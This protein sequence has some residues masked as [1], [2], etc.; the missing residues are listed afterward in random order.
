M[1]RIVVLENPIAHMNNQLTKQYFTQMLTMKK[2]GYDF[3][4]RG[5]NKSVLPFDHTDFIGN[6][7]LLLNEDD[8]ILLCYKVISF[9]ACTQY[10]KNFAAAA[11]FNHVSNHYC[12]IMEL[13]RR[14]ERER[15][16][17]IYCSA[18]TINPSIRD[19]LDTSLLVHKIF[20]SIVLNYYSEYKV[21]YMMV[22]ANID[23]NTD[24]TFK[25]MGMFPLHGLE[26]ITLRSF[27]DSRI[28]IFLSEGSFSKKSKKLAKKY[29]NLWKERKIIDQDFYLDEIQAA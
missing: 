28:Q 11:P 14:A 3:A 12:Q 20:H 6:H 4:F 27:G 13:T 2:S 21:G 5:K 9:K 23:F 29:K 1:L 18:F 15:K 22:L 8:Q 26:A 17:L 16:E 10:G 25:K 24:T 19:D 7:I